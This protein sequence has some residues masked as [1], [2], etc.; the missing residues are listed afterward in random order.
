VYTIF[1]YDDS[2]ETQ[3]DNFVYN[4]SV[5]G[6]FLQTK[7]FLNYHPKER[8][9]DKSILLFKENVLIAVVPG[10]SIDDEGRKTFFSHAGSTFGGFV[11]HKKYYDA[12]NI[13]EMIKF[14]ENKLREGSFEKIVLKIT[15]DIF[16]KE[17][18]DVLQ[19]ALAYCGYDDY[20]ELST[21]IDFETY[22]QDISDNFNHGQRGK[23]K[24]ALK[25][26]MCLK[27]INND[28]EISSFY[29]ILK[30]NL[31][32]FNIFPV[33]SIEELLDFKNNRLK[34]IVKF[35]GILLKNKMIAGGMLFDFGSILHA[36][37]LSVDYDYIKYRP[38]TYLYY[39]LIELA[40]QN[41][42]KILS[43][44]ISTEKRGAVLN[45]SL[46]SFKESFGSKYSLNR[47][48]YKTF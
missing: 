20:Y 27:E 30:K 1:F 29:D 10:C 35:Y 26:D 16:S 24:Q 5:N 42:Y 14:L 34:G 36:Q 43:W 17:K 13:I 21:Y 41:G 23:L 39:K 28:E 19:Y 9:I 4:D 31:L 48:F 15:P 33:H 44:G 7:K 22:K 32:K 37:Y 25:N 2:Y 45:E 11:I 3:W 46:L 18:S 38:M 12:V 8:F 40:S 47:G 6:T